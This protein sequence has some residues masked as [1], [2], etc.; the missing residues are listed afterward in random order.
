MGVVVVAAGRGERAGGG[1]PKQLREVAGAPLVLHAVR[2]FLR[3][4][5]VDQVILVLPP[6]VAAS[7]PAWLAPLIGDRLRVVAGG[8]ERADSVRHGLEALPPSAAIVLVHDGARPNPDAEVI[9]AVIAVARTGIGAIAAVPVTDTLKEATP[10]GDVARTVPR[11]RLWRAQTP[12]GFPRELLVRA[13]AAR[14]PAIHDT[15]EAMMVERIGGT[16]RLVPDTV[17]NLK[18]T[19]AE[20]LALA[21]WLLAGARR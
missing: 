11:H 19:S 10:A 18:V 4:A 14:D 12:Q 6:E 15:D 9:A 1:V 3:R 5:E 17:Q 16:V 8:E 13:I 7:P 20:D 21:D 2:A